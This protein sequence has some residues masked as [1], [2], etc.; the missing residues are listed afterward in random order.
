M[1]ELRAEGM[2]LRAVRDVLAADGVCVSHVAIGNALR[3]PTTA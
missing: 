2:S 1:R 3:T